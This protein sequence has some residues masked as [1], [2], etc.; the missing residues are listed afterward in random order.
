MAFVSAYYH[1]RD[2]WRDGLFPPTLPP[3]PGD[4]VELFHVRQRCDLHHLLALWHWR[5]LAWS[6][7]SARTPNSILDDKARPVLNDRALPAKDGKPNTVGTF[8]VRKH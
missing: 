5:P 1:K 4:A 6:G 7:L 3:L 2:I 8:V